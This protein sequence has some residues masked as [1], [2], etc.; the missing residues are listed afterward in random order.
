MKVTQM[1][2]VHAANLV[3]NSGHTAYRVEGI[4]SYHTTINRG[5]AWTVCSWNVVDIHFIILK[6]SFWATWIGNL[7][8]P[9]NFFMP[10]A[11]WPMEL[12][13]HCGLVTPDVVIELGHYTT[14]LLVSLCPS[15]RPPHIS[16]LLCSAYSSGWIHFIFIH[17]IE[18]LQKVCGLQNFKIWISGNFLKICNF[19]FVLFWLGIWCESQVW[20]IMGRWGYLRT[21]AF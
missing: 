9:C 3:A 13:S 4:A 19:D 20:V 7:L 5:K 21:L 2:P 11:N 16:C 1:P 6:L 15:V 18:Q 10:W 14:K 12:L 8:A 17:L